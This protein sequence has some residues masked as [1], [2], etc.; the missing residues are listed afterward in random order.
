MSDLAALHAKFSDK[1]PRANQ[2]VKITYERSTIYA[3][4]DY[5]VVERTDTFNLAGPYAGNPDIH[6]GVQGFFLG[7]GPYLELQ[8][9]SLRGPLGWTWEADDE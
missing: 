4:A 5:P 6:H 2:R 9:D 8:W 1:L 3:L 7:Y